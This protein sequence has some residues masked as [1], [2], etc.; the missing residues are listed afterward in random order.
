[1]RRTNSLIISNLEEGAR[2][3]ANRTR[4]RRD[5]C[6]RCGG[7]RTPVVARS[8]PVTGQTDPYRAPRTIDGRP[9]LNGVWQARQHGQ[10]RPAGPSG[11]TGIGADTGTTAHRSPGLEP[12][13]TGGASRTSRPCTRRGR[14]RSGRRRRRRGQRHPLPALGS[15]AEEGERRPLAGA[16]SGNQVLHARCAARH[17]HAVSVPDS[18]ERRQGPDRLRICGNDAHDSH[19]RR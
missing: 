12:V 5:C 10:L 13:D 3:H 8:P 1:M 7:G 17:L 9:D 6:C 19:E 14:R 16:R 15:G 4:Q 11:A 18:S 2:D